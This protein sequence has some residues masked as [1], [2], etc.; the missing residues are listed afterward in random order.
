MNTVKQIL[1]NLKTGAVSVTDVPAPVVRPE[2]RVAT[3][4]STS[5]TAAA[6]A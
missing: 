3:A 4:V 6:P 2:R 5:F 1:Q